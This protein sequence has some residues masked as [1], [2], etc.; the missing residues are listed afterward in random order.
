MIDPKTAAAVPLPLV[1]E[2]GNFQ[3]GHVRSHTV[4]AQQTAAVDFYISSLRLYDILYDVLLHFYSSESQSHSK[5]G[6]YDTCFKYFSTFENNAS[7]FEL[8]GRLS[9]WEN[10]VPDYLKVRDHSQD[11]GTNAVLV[12]R[13]VILHQRYVGRIYLMV[14]Y[15]LY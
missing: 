11:N 14:N 9:R 10:G 12:R 7:I 13:A 3:L 5:M 6:R 4:Q 8:Q 15:T 1:M 2:E